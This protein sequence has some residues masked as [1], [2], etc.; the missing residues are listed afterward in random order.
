MDPLTALS[1]AAS[2]VQFVDYGTKLLSKGRELYK[3]ADGALSENVELEG[4][5]S[6]LN[7]LSSDLQKSLRGGGQG[8]VNERDE[9]LETICKGCIEVSEDLTARLK[10]LMLPSDQKHRVWESFK[11]T[12]K[13]VLSKEK[14]EEADLKLAKLRSE[15][16]THVI[17][18][19]R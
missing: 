16:D 7:L 13:T 14:I 17:L 8:A 3:S 1:I 18:S 12:L 11:L 9:A 15:L 2:V 6:R 5:S 10:K 4:A 19:I